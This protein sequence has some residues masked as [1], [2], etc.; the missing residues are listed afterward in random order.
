MFLFFTETSI[1]WASN[2]WTIS[3]SFPNDK[4]KS[5]F[6]K[7][8]STQTECDQLCSS[9]PTCSHYLWSKQSNGTCNLRRGRVH[10]SEVKRNI[11]NTAI[12]GVK[13]IEW[14]GKDSANHCE[15]V[16]D[17]FAAFNS[18]IDECHSICRAFDNC[19][20]FNW[21]Q[22][23]CQ[24]MSGKVSKDEAFVLSDDGSV[25]VCGI[26]KDGAVVWNEDDFANF[27]DFKG[28][29][30]ESVKSE[31]SQC[32]TLCLDKKSCNHFSWSK[33]TCSLKSARIAQRDAIFVN[34]RTFVCGFIKERLF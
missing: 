1:I 23:S 22:N 11:E 2:N 30:F 4:I 26:V 27:C 7:I 19:S 28:N 18:T 3:C 25:A 14:N 20:H 12:C 17:V 15:F 13:D 9:N 34:D 24:V 16:D 6:G 29:S 33:G 5:D 32:R 10:K 21:K 8:I 31:A